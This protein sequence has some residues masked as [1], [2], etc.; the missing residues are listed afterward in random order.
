MQNFSLLELEKNVKQW[1]KA[2]HI[3]N[4]WSERVFDQK[5]IVNKKSINNGN[6][7]LGSHNLIA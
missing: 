4:I 7:L 1:Q 2:F 3:K 5:K 6:L